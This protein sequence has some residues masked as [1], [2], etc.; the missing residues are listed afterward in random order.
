MTIWNPWH[1]CRKISAGC[2]NCYVY[3]RDESNGKDASVVSKT[4]DYALAVRKN[5]QGG[6][7]LTPDDGVVYTCMTSDFFLEEADEWRPGCWDM[8]RERTDLKFHIITKRIDRAG[9]CFPPDWGDGWDHVTICSTCENQDRTDCRLPILLE[10]PIRH[11]EVIAEPMLGEIDM[12]QYL[13]TGLIEHVTCG[14]ESG[15]RAR[16]CDFRWILKVRSQCVRCGVAFTFKQTGAVFIKDGRTYHIARKDQ[17]S[18]ARK[19]GC[20]YT[21]GAGNASGLQY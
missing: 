3:R 14:G 1:G 6:Y 17:M 5:R 8:I 7:K 18:Q 16:P 2:A 15:P 21:P 11:R 12:E 13:A 20:S 4:G 19:S 9:K 10:L